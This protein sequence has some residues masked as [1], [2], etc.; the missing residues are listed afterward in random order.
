MNVKQKRKNRHNPATHDVPPVRVLDTGVDLCRPARSAKCRPDPV[1]LV[2]A[3][4]V[5]NSPHTWL[6]HPPDEIVDRLCAKYE[7]GNGRLR[8]YIAMIIADRI[9]KNI[10]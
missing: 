2:S 9:Q 7:D 3:H 5:T 8:D 1:R 10:K 4:A 6:F